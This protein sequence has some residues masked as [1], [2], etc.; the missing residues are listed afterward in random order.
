MTQSSRN[1]R[2]VT[3]DAKDH[4]LPPSDLLDRIN[5]YL[6]AKL[7][8]QGQLYLQDQL[9]R[10][11]LYSLGVF[12]QELLREETDRLFEDVWDTTSEIQQ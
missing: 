4:D 10:S 3:M 9:Q 5:T 1:G 7:V 8:S 11:A 2:R 6:H 12:T